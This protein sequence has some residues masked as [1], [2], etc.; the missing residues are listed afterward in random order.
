MLSP[1]LVLSTSFVTLLLRSSHSH[2]PPPG[3]HLIPFEEEDYQVDPVLPANAPLPPSSRMLPNGK[4]L[5]FPQP[6]APSIRPDPPPQNHRRDGSQSAIDTTHSG[7]YPP[8]VRRSGRRS[9]TSS[10]GSWAK[11]GGRPDIQR[12][13]TGAA[14]PSAYFSPKLASSSASLFSLDPKQFP[15]P[16]D[17]QP[18]RYEFSQQPVFAPRRS[19]RDL[20]GV[21]DTAS[22]YSAIPPTP[23][24][25]QRGTSAPSE[26][27]RP[28]FYDPQAPPMP[29]VPTHL[30]GAMSPS[31]ESSTDN[32]SQQIE[33][34]S[35]FGSTMSLGGVPRPG[36][37]GP[38]S[39]S[40]SSDSSGG[41]VGRRY[42][43]SAPAQPDSPIEPVFLSA[44]SPYRYNRAPVIEVVVPLPPGVQWPSGQ[45][46]KLCHRELDGCGLLGK[47]KMGDLV[48][49]LAISHPRRTH[50]P[51]GWTT[52]TMVFVPPYLHPLSTAH[53]VPPPRS[54][55]PWFPPAHLPVSIDMFLLP[56]TYFHAVLPTPYIVH[57]DLSPFEQP[58]RSSLRLAHQ[59]NE[60]TS[61]SGQTLFVD[62]WIHE[63]GFFIGRRN[64]EVGSPNPWDG[65]MV[66]LEADGTQ[67]GREEILQRV[68]KGGSGRHPW[69]IIGS[70]S[71]RGSVWLKSVC[72]FLHRL[73]VSWAESSRYAFF[74]F[75]FFFLLVINT[76]RLVREN[77]P[78]RHA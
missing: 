54:S 29:P 40:G 33:D 64:G 61:A 22:T 25:R 37:L 60:M 23:S 8:P 10:V 75:S 62:L 49:N 57:L 52:G 70:K 63:A 42:I 9:S 6:L 27:A 65:S 34:D 20:N 39:S 56:P 50:H 3:R 7:M 55:A 1:R 38:G 71:T 24:L 48:E 47:M 13:G 30:W 4:E 14:P 76:F 73:F 44:T 11:F 35:P 67:E 32:L 26:S 46:L 43:P 68:R 12:G 28:S 59:K 18:I 72:P 19:R 31:T 58:I 36:F 15:L 45:A 16:R 74:F 51:N 77:I 21:S 69:E 2:R 17:P 5:V 41:I 53:C 66:T 78:N